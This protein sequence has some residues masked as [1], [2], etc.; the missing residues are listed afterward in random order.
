MNNT[1]DNKYPVMV[2]LK[3]KFGVWKSSVRTL[4]G[5]YVCGGKEALNYDIVNVPPPKTTEE[6]WVNVYPAAYSSVV[7]TGPGYKSKDDAR[8]N[9]DAGRIACVKAT[10]TYSM[11]EGL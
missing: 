8:R 3:D 4:D 10:I 6:I 7:V 5:S 9:A 1:G 11:G 2:A